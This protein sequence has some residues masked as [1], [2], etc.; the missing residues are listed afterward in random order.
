LLEG[1]INKWSDPLWNEAL[2]TTIAWHISANAPSTTNEARI[3]LCQI[4]LE[5]LASLRGF[6]KG[7]ANQRILEL[8][9]D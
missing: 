1:F 5:V 4:A 9:Q 7:P 6:E 3:T 8:L 2:R